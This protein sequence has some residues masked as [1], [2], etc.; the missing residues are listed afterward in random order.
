MDDYGDPG[1]PGVTQAVT[2]HLDRGS[3]LRL[4]GTVATSAFLTVP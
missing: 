1:W 4:Q 2:E 3:K